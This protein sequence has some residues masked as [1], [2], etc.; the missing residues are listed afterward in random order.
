[1]GDKIKDI[2]ILNPK[3]KL[4]FNKAY[5]NK[6]GEWEIEKKKTNPCFY[7]VFV[8]YKLNIPNHKLFL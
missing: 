2:Q 6:E 3:G 5:K 7:S 8:T 1:M 4:F